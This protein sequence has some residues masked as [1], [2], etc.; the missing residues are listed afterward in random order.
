[1]ALRTAIEAARR[2]RSLRRLFLLEHQGVYGFVLWL[3]TIVR[4]SSTLLRWAA[5]VYSPPCL[6]PSQSLR[7]SWCLGA[8]IKLCNADRWSGRFYCFGGAAPGGFFPRSHAH[9]TIAFSSLIVAGACMY[10]PY[11][12][13]FAIVPE[14]LPRSVAAEVIALVNGAGALGGF[15]WHLFYVGWLQGVTGSSRGRLSA[16]ELVTALFGGADVLPARS[17]DRRTIGLE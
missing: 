17:K 8:P 7:C 15:V 4:Q 2:T 9:F 14:R 12:P 11:G 1:M 6:M 10:A 3:P 13:F 5:R 16:D